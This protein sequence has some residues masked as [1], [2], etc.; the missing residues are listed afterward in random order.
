MRHA[1][2]EYERGGGGGTNETYRAPTLPYQNMPKGNPL[3]STPWPF[4][5]SDPVFWSITT[6]S[7]RHPP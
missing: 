5:F 6:S 1:T 7:P 3:P 2:I 4:S